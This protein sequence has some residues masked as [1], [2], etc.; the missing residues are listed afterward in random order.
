MSP[1]PGFPENPRWIVGD[2]DVCLQLSVLD[3][4]NIFHALAIDYGVRVV[5]PEAVENEI[6]NKF[7]GAKFRGHSAPFRKAI[8]SGI[9]G[10]V[11]QSWIRTAY[12]PDDGGI[13]EEINELGEDL[14]T[15]VHRG[16]AY[17]HASAIVLKVPCLTNDRS[18][19]NTLRRAGRV[20]PINIL[21]S[22]DIL[23]FGFQAGIISIKE[24]EEMR[25]TLTAAG[26][27][28]PES[29]ARCSFEAGLVNFFSRLLDSDKSL[30]GAA[31]PEDILDK[32]LWITKTNIARSA[33]PS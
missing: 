33:G 23:V 30:C 14:Y 25:A 5:I 4:I 13:F 17:A 22:F 26:E 29:F 3:K 32:R 31:N 12:G 16:E 2:T 15:M 11:N 6:E 9:I 10:I 8:K 7:Q 1:V 18:A 27:G 24:C 19:V 28:L 20:L 21:R